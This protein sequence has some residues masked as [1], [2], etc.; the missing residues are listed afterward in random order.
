[1]ATVISSFRAHLRI[2]AL[3]R[4]LL[5]GQGLRRQ[6]L[7]FGLQIGVIAFAACA[8]V[9]VLNT[10]HSFRQAI[11][12]RLFGYMGALWIRAYGEEQESRPLPIDT[13]DIPALPHL[14][15][16]AAIHLPTLL[17]GPGQRYAGLNLVAVAPTWWQTA[18]KD[19]LSAPLPSWQGDSLLV[20]SK[21][22]AEKLGVREGDRVTAFWL[23]DPPRARRLQIVALYQ[24]NIDE[25]DRYVGFVPMQ[26]GQTLLD[27]SP[28][29]VQTLHIFL[30]DHLSADS[31]AEALS[32]QLPYTYEILPVE[33]IFQDIFDWIGLIQQNV[34]FILAIVLGLSFFSVASAFLVL[35]MV[36]R[37]RYELCWALG[38]RPS[39]LWLLT[40][41]QA[42][43]SLGLGVLL[44]EGLAALVLYSQ[45]RWQWLQLDPESYLISTVPVYW[46]APAFLTV[47]G[48]GIGLALPLT[49]IAYPKR[50]FVRLLAHTE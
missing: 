17:E 24:A 36:Q 32:W 20:L 7:I 5:L 39:Q 1:M 31:L 34:Q 4:R 46:H 35:Q 9:L 8:G 22:V 40:A 43:F 10:A 28:T 49:L 38:T 18:W 15:A 2:G 30:P 50:R 42:V 29:Q 14:Q 26:L 16:E 48:V 25:L 21:A 11:T 37:L 6:R 12:Q 27:W 44:G 33:V 19:L 45:Q 3:A 23:A 47:A 41:Y 13:R